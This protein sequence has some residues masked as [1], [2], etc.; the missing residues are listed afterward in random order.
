MGWITSVNMICIRKRTIV[1][2]FFVSP[3]FF[4]TLI[5]TF[6]F[7]FFFFFSFLS[8]QPNNVKPELLEIEPFTD[9]DQVWNQNTDLDNMGA[10]PPTLDYGMSITADPSVTHSVRQENLREFLDGIPAYYD[11][12]MVRGGR[13]IK[14]EY[15]TVEK[16]NHYMKD[17]FYLK[18]NAPA[19]N[20]QVARE[21]LFCSGRG[22][23]VRRCG[24]IGACIKGKSLFATHFFFFVF[25][26]SNF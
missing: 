12:I 5:I 23:C 24:G 19:K 15:I 3:S 22:N 18:P 4:F 11:A 10:Q 20:V 25:F 13:F 8:P 7:P 16:G 26:I 1:F 2:I 9:P 21:T 6:S 17:K 14:S